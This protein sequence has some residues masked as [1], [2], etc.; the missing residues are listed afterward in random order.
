M[1]VKIAQIT[2]ACMECSNARSLNS[3]LRSSQR[4][5]V[6]QLQRSPDV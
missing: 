2:L 1:L 4:S 6:R 5:E 3:D